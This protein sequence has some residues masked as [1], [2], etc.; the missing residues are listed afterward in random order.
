MNFKVFVFDTMYL[1]GLDVE[2]VGNDHW[3]LEGRGRI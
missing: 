3:S 2:V 1:D